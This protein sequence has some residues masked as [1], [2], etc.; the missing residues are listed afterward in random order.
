MAYSIIYLWLIIP[1]LRIFLM[2][3]V[4]V[5]SYG[6]LVQKKK[7]TQSDDD[8]QTYHVSKSKF[9]TLFQELGC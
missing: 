1:L 4:L 8:L 7:K 6:E 5:A 9:C 3:S 2:H